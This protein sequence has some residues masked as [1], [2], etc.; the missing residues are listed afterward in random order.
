MGFY[1][2]HVLPHLI[3]LAMRSQHLVPYRKRVLSQ[4]EGRVLEIG[5]GSGMNLPFYPAAATEIFGLD[6]HPQLLAM[7]RA[8]ERGLLVTAYEGSAES[9]PLDDRSFDT[10]VM[11]WTLCSIPDAPRA[12]Q[13][14]RRVLKPG[15]QLLFVEHGVAPEPKVQRWQRRL[16]PVWKRITGGCHLDRPVERLVR[17]SGFEIASLETGYMQGPN[18]M[19]FTYEGRARPR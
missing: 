16:T 11:T 3:N 17:Q 5:L 7:A 4:A 18:P 19:T 12:L 1:A 6:P 2:S 9:I 15:G 8:R 10:V 14:V 13:E